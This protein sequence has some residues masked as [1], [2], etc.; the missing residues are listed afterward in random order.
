M[1][2]LIRKILREEFDDFGWAEELVGN[3]KQFSPAEEFLYEIMSNL[4][5]VPSKN[6]PGLMLYKNKSGVTLMADDADRDEKNPILL[7]NYDKIWRKLNQ[8]FGLNNQEIKDLCVRMLEMTHKRKVLTAEV[9][10]VSAA[11][12]LE[13]THKRKVLTAEFRGAISALSWK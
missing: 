11:H 8:K 10:F 4:T 12:S 6:S 9:G 13:M 3:T 1:K 2:N 5:M 7:V